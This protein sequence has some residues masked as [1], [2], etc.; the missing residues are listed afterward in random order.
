M[1]SFHVYVMQMCIFNKIVKNS[2]LPRCRLCG[3][4]V[5]IG[6][7]VVSFPA[8]GTRIKH[9]LYHRECFEKTLH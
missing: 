4:P 6:D 7:E 2:G 1:P 9:Y 5:Q 3:E 8:V